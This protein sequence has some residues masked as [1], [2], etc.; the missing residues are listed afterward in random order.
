MTEEWEG[1]SLTKKLGVASI[2]GGALQAVIPVGTVALVLHDPSRLDLGMIG[3]YAAAS[4]LWT[5]LLAAGAAGLYYRHQDAFEW[6]GLI[7]T[8]LVLVGFL[9]GLTGGSLQLVTGDLGSGNVI[10]WMFTQPEI[11]GALLLG[12]AIARADE[13]PH[14]VA[15]G[16]LLAVAK[17]VSFGLFFFFVKYISPVVDSV[18]LFEEVAL[19]F[20]GM[21]LLYGAAWM[22]LGYDLV[23]E[24]DWAGPAA[25]TGSPEREGHGAR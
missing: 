25:D 3:N 12:A 10:V 7:G 6:P 19:V 18:G 23:T 14:A 21:T 11:L 16:L 17:P 20:A 22:L 13:L 9:T 24:P 2:L 15:G 5:L 4:K 8:A 1:A